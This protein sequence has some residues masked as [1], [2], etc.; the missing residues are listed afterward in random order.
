MI[1]LTPATRLSL[2][3]VILTLSILILAESL[4][5]TP[6]ESKQ[7]LQIRQQ[8]VETLGVQTSVALKHSNSLQLQ[9]ILNN[10]VSRNSSI[11]SAA[12]RRSDG[13]LWLF[14]G[15][16]KRFWFGA[17]PDKSTATHI[18][19]PLIVNG[20]SRNTLE[21][22]FKDIGSDN[23]QLFGLPKFVLLAIFVSISGFIGFWIYIKRALKHLDPSA[24]VP[25]RVKNA[26]NILSEGV[27]ILD[28]REQIVL[29]NETF[30]LITGLTE[31]A[32][33]GSKISIL[34]W[35]IPVDSH[36]KKLPWQEAIITLKR[37]SGERLEYTSKREQHYIF[38]VNAV[39]ILDGRDHCQGTIISFNDITELESKTRMLENTMRKIGRAQIAIEKKNRELSFLAS[40]D[41]MTSCFN[42]RSLY[43]YLDTNFSDAQ[44]KELPFCCI[45]TDIDHFK[46]VNDTYGHSVGDEIIKMV[47]A[48]LQK[49]VRDGDIVS[50][51]GGE[52]FCIILPGASVQIASQVAERCR[53]DI[54]SRTTEN[55]KVTS[56]FGVSTLSFGA[57]TP[58]ALIHQADEALYNSKERG[59]NKV[60]TWRPEMAIDEANS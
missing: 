21:V 6:S 16:H 7:Q 37:Q 36:L 14:A 12:I 54:A 11:L 53:A 4:G 57:D 59:R 26:L 3:L 39:P 40:R 60:S 34:P 27:V 13:S 25:A 58:Q 5:L 18:R 15:D 41:P 45:M 24:V 48:C 49:N 10:T 33:I 47:A 44:Q 28:Q 38:T 55:V 50:R 42:R 46:N 29:V 17:E 56:S 32:L 19:L 52:E 51:Y 23:Q 30:L 9:A 20:V 2:G 31:Q 1:K 43:E 22:T 8:L 35:K